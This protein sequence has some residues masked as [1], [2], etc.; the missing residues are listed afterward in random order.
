MKARV[1]ICALFVL[2]L[3]CQKKET[4]VPVVPGGD[5]VV[6]LEEFTG[7]GCT[8][9]P[10]GN[11]EIDN[12]LALYDSNLVV[13]SIHAGTFADPFFF[14]VGQ[15]DLRT[16]DGNSIFQM[17]GPNL[18]YPSGVVDRIRFNGEFQQGSQAWADLVAQ[19]VGVD[20]LV[21]FVTAHTY[22]A[23]ERRIQL[24]ISGITRTSIEGELRVS[25]MLTE[26]GIIDAQ[27]DI[28]QGGIVD[29]YVHNH[30]LRSM[31][32]PFDG[33]IVVNDPA[34]GESFTQQVTM[35]VSEDWDAGKIKLIT[36]VT[37]VKGPADFRVL[38]A[39]SADLVE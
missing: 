24:D 35:T 18:G 9:C 20:P 39:S 30:V 16:D 27:D 29:D 11:R 37:N 1:L 15:Y 2:S 19:E 4:I 22:D 3:G 36:F 5:R 38:Q 25:V 13:V 28:E 12:L 33:T 14:P 17:L 10:K 26:D 32:T 34:S 31:G 8:N 7:K 6:L 23:E 21:D